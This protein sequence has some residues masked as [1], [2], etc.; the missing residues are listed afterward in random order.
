MATPCSVKAI[1]R[2]ACDE[3]CQRITFCDTPMDNPKLASSWVNTNIKITRKTLDI[4]FDR[5][6]QGSCFHLVEFRQM[7]I[8][9]H[10]ATPYFKNLVLDN[11]QVHNHYFKLI[12]IPL[13]FF[14]YL[15]C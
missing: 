4:A 6:L 2:W 11:L 3:S 12:S 14:C 9:H 13:I 15:A 1:G 7:V 8:E 10:P 5:L